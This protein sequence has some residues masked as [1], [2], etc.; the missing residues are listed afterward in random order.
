[1]KMHLTPKP[2]LTTPYAARAHALKVIYACLEIE[3]YSALHMAAP[4]IKKRTGWDVTISAQKSKDRIQF[5]DVCLKTNPTID[6]QVRRTLSTIRISNSSESP[7]PFMAF[8]Y[9]LSTHIVGNKESSDPTPYMGTIVRE[10]ER[11]VEQAEYSRDEFKV[12]LSHYAQEL[13]DLAS[14]LDTASKEL[15][16]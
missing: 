8:V 9:S 6:G 3:N 5:F 16:E 11:N 7:R 15:G 2:W 4:I 1:M 10:I 12:Y 14:Q 13:R